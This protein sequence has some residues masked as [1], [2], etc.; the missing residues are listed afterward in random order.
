MA[1]GLPII[2]SLKAG[3]AELLT[4]GVDGVL[5]KE[6]RDAEE[7]AEK[8]NALVLSPEER[9]KIGAAARQTAENYSWKRIAEIT[10]QSYK[11]IWGHKE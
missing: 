2:T 5:L 1:S 11:K 10:Y 9:Q 3:A 8:I 4:D 7:L 6:S